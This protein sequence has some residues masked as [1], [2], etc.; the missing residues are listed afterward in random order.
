MKPL[1]KMWTLIVLVRICGHKKASV[2]LMLDWWT[3]TKCLK[4]E[5]VIAVQFRSWHQTDFFCYVFWIGLLLQWS[6]FYLQPPKQQQKGG[7]TS[8]KAKPSGSGGKAKKKKW[9][10]G[11]VRDKL[12][13]LVLFDKPTYDKLYKEVGSQQ[14]FLFCENR[15]TLWQYYAEIYLFNAV[16]PKLGVNYPQGGIC[17]SLVGNVYTNTTLFYIMSDYCKM[18]WVIKT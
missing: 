2:I 9:S 17:D 5:G 4:T 10:K 8:Q 18:L 11:K 7:K 12:N 15:E 6:I 14:H 3:F 16:V 1:G 13:N